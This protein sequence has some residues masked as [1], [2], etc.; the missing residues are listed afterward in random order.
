MDNAIEAAINLE[1]EKVI[2]LKLARENHSLIISVRNTV[3][4]RV[5]IKDN[6]ISTTKSDK[7]KHG[8]GISSIKKILDKYSAELFMD[9]DDKWFQSSTIVDNA[10]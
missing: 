4:K 5:R 7:R 9:C 3:D 1:Q 10:F 6:S 2:E 8:L